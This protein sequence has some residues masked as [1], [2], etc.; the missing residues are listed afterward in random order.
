[1]TTQTYDPK[2][3][4]M[5]LHPS[6]FL[7]VEDLKVRW[8]VQQLAVTIARI[9]PED[10]IPN[11]KDLDSATADSRNPNGKPRVIVQPVLYFQTKTGAPFPRG[12]LLS[13]Q[14][15]VASLMEATKAETI[16][17]VIGKK[18]IIYIGEHRK[19]EVLRISPT[20]PEYPNVDGYVSKEIIAGNTK[21]PTPEG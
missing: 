13:T 21:P 20:A 5:D 7:K 2:T 4:L 8:H 12:Y 6:R 11:P 17:E 19:Q 10:T 3:P 1:M 15:D 18:I 14:V 16:G 9:A